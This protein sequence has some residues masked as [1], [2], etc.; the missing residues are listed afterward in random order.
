[1]FVSL[2]P[3]NFFVAGDSRFSTPD[4]EPPAYYRG[5]KSLSSFA[6]LFMDRIF[7]ATTKT[8]GA[9]SGFEPEPETLGKSRSVVKLRGQNGATGGSSTRVID[10]EDRGPMRWTTVAWWVPGVTIPVLEVKSQLLHHTR[11]AS[12]H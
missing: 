5:P 12:Y 8:L 4:E 3:R 6:S 9:S 7:S 2:Y 10:L 1:M 11:E